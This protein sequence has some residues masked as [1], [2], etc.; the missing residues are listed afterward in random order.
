MRIAKKAKRNEKNIY[1]H[2]RVSL[3]LS[4]I[5]AHEGSR[6]R[7]NKNKKLRMSAKVKKTLFTR[8]TPSL[9]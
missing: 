6:A 8:P 1:T 3:A 7:F 4:P 5:S 9:A 2:V